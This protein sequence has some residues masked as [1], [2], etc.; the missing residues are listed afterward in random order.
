LWHVNQFG[1]PFLGLALRYS[2]RFL[3]Y[4]GTLY[5]LDFCSIRF[6]KSIVSFVLYDLPSQSFPFCKYVALRLILHARCLWSPPPGGPSTSLPAFT[7]ARMYCLRSPPSGGPSTSVA[8]S[9]SASCIVFG[10]PSS[11][12]LLHCLGPT[13]SWCPFYSNSLS[14]R[15][16]ISL[17]S[18]FPQHGNVYGCCLIHCLLDTFAFVYHPC[19]DLIGLRF[20]SASSDLIARLCSMS[21]Q[22][23]QQVL[24]RTL[25]RSMHWVLCGE[26]PR[27]SWSPYS[28]GPSPFIAASS[29]PLLNCLWSPP[30]TSLAASTSALMYCLGPH[31]SGGPSTSV[32]A[33]TSALL[34]CLGP[35]PSWCHF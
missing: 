18:G 13:T 1:S 33:S 9:T 21:D 8:A 34:Y 27:A 24:E 29:S 16:D 32:A 25:L 4:A 11:P 20:G 28:C 12:A 22:Q 35:P 3:S 30:S 7:S 23:S 6:A 15:I 19:I 5:L 2:L 31:P 17:G 10:P 26:P 14:L